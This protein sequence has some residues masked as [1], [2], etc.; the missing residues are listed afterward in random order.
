MSQ[1]QI[2]AGGGGAPGGAAV[3]AAGPAPPPYASHKLTDFAKNAA[4][5]VSSIFFVLLG[6]VLLAIYAAERTSNTDNVTINNTILALIVVT[7][8]LFMYF[9]VIFL[10]DHYRYREVYRQI[11][12]N[13][14]WTAQQC[15]A[16]VTEQFTAAEVR[17]YKKVRQLQYL[18]GILVIMLC[19]ATVGLFWSE[20][21]NSN[22]HSRPEYSTLEAVASSAFIMALVVHAI[23]PLYH[24][25][26]N[27]NASSIRPAFSE[28]DGATVDRPSKNG[29]TPTRSS[30]DDNNN[31]SSS[32]NNNNNN[33]DMEK[34]RSE[35]VFGDSSLEQL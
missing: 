29:Y 27:C 11:K 1:P 13:L 34:L 24:K 9:L 7:F 12:N 5:S 26:R 33:I 3:A 23:E 22:E 4:I 14:N 31:N 17:Q 15:K 18:I 10:M 19:A 6:V 21:G 2:A 35:N 30:N 16:T 25:L 20:I 8:L 32:S 28:L